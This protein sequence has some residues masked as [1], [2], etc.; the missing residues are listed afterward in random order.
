MG[1]AQAIREATLGQLLDE[2]VAK[3]PGP[4]RRGPTWTASSAS[5][6]ASSPDLVDEVALGLLA[7]GVQK[8][9]KV[10][11]W[12]NN[13]PYWVVLMFATAQD[14][15]GASDREHPLPQV[16]ESSTC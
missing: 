3:W 7:M 9:E 2:T 14:R 8:G 1:R 11:L 12:A 6:G 13:V 16:R 15:R 5:P 4:R 10:G